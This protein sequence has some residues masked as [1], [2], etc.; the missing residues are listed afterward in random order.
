VR[1]STSR[2]ASR[3]E[4]ISASRPSHNQ[5]RAKVRGAPPE[6]VMICEFTIYPAK[7][8]EVYGKAA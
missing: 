5:A 2:M 8:M 3:P 4:P 1:D 6:I 7:R